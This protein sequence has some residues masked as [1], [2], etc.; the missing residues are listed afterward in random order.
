MIKDRERRLAWLACI[1]L[2]PDMPVVPNV[3]P[4]RRELGDHTRQRRRIWRADQDDAAP[5]QRFTKPPQR[6]FDIGKMLDHVVADHQIE[7]VARK[8]MSLDIAENLVLG[9]I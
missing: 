1:L 2:A 9:V 3:E 4:V 5:A 8:A 6:R 7:T